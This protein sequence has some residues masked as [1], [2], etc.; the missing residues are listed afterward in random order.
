MAGRQRV[1]S[2]IQAAY[3]WTAGLDDTIASRACLT[4]MAKLW[5]VEQPMTHPAAPTSPDPIVRRSE[6]LTKDFLRGD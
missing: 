3:Q 4:I 6:L 2:R 5:R 1:E